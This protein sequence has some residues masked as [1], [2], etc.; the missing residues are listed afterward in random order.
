MYIEKIRDTWAYNHKHLLF[1]IS[2]IVALLWVYY[3]NS[4]VN[5]LP[6]NNTVVYIAPCN[7]LECL[8]QART[9]EIF[10]RDE[11]LYFEQA[12]TN[13]MNDIGI[14]V[15]KMMYNPIIKQ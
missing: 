4:L 14:E 8:I 13:A 6:A 3:G 9:L 1:T 10:K 12:K 2:L 11:W 15:V 5:L 7:T